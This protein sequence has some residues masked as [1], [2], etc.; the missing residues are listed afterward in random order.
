MS[1][2]TYTTAVTVLSD[3]TYIKIPDAAPTAGWVASCAAALQTSTNFSNAKGAGLVSQYGHP[4][5]GLVDAWGINIS[6]CNSYC[7]SQAIPMVCTD[8]AALA[9]SIGNSCN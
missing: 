3:T 6:A 5:G 1:F 2:Y 9:C 8:T 7:S 4:A